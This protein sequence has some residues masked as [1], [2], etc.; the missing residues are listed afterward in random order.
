MLLALFFSKCMATSL[1]LLVIKALDSLTRSECGIM[2]FLGGGN[3][4]AESGYQR[5][6]DALLAKPV[7][8][9]SQWMLICWLIIALFGSTLIW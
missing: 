7:N 1:R 6:V 3:G 8:F 4:T 9:I 2:W 5:L